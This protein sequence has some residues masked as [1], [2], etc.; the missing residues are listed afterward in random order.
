MVRIWD[1]AERRQVQALVGHVQHVTGVSFS[2]DG[3]LLATSSFDGTVRIWDEATGLPLRLIQLSEPVWDVAFSPDGET[4]ATA[5][6]A[7]GVRI[8]DACTA[9]RDPEALFDLAQRRVTRELTPEERATFQGEDV[10]PIEPPISEQPPATAPEQ[11]LPGAETASGEVP[12]FP[13]RTPEDVLALTRTRPTSG[14]VR[15]DVE[16]WADEPYQLEIAQQGLVLRFHAVRPDGERWI[17]LD[18]RTAFLYFCDAPPGGQPTCRD[19]EAVSQEEQSAALN[20]I[21][22]FLLD[23]YVTQTYQ[24]VLATAGV[25]QETHLGQPV[26][27]LQAEGDEEP[28]ELC[29]TAFSF[30]ARVLDGKR[31]RAVATELRSTVQAAELEPPAPLS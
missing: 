1:V 2:P 4:V 30:P 14:F 25:A 23:S 15:L 31:L 27:C 8:W 3:T 7:G 28:L 24:P 17:G 26:S 21:A 9:C 16:G 22:G 13:A 20:D 18:T 6:E 12:A 19:P 10:G 29:V 5:D 11:E